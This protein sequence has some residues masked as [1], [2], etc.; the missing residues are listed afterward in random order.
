MHVP[1]STCQS[2]KFVR[3]THLHNLATTEHLHT[4]EILFKTILYSSF[5]SCLKCNGQTLYLQNCFFFH[6]LFFL[7]LLLLRKLYYLQARPVGLYEP[8]RTFLLYGTAGILVKKALWAW[9]FSLLF[10]STLS[11]YSGDNHQLVLAG[12]SA[13]LG[14]LCMI[15]KAWCSLTI[16]GSHSTIDPNPL[17]PA[18]TLSECS[19]LKTQWCSEKSIN[20][21][22]EHD[23][24]L[25]G[26][27]VA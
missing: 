3:C 20:N 9:L 16:A 11:F 10:L 2:N 7:S 13:S 23:S 5:F 19:A 21:F 12:S 26:H 4:M 25:F 6:Y 24:V 1:L 14:V 22:D 8:A 17:T 27:I 15:L 18:N